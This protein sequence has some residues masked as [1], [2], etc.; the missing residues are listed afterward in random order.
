MQTIQ[1][2][3]SWPANSI[4]DLKLARSR[5]W[6]NGYFDCDFVLVAHHR[7]LNSLEN[8][9][10]NLNFTYLGWMLNY[11]LLYDYV[12]EETLPLDEAVLYATKH[13]VPII[14][15]FEELQVIPKD[16]YIKLTEV[17]YEDD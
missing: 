10:A 14:R 6:D 1:A 5:L 17:H 15:Q 11:R 2:A 7:V 8:A 16:S 12:A 3:G 13:G 9:I 4:S